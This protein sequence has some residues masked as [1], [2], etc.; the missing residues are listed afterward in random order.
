MSAIL[1]LT[2]RHVFLPSA[3]KSFKL[4][5][6]KISSVS[7]IPSKYPNWWTAPKSIAKSPILLPIVIISSF[8][9]NTP[10]GMFCIGKSELS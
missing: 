5:C 2:N 1:F 4:S 7:G 3:I 6:K 10:K 8:V 9:I